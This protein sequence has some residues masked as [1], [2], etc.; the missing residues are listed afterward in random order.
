MERVIEGTCESKL[1][2]LYSLS[3]CLLQQEMETLVA[4]NVSVVANRWS[5]DG[6]RSSR[7]FTVR[8]IVEYRSANPFRAKSMTTFVR[9]RATMH[10]TGFKSRHFPD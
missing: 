7:N 2:G 1:R 4:A 5:S 3:C 8:E 9:V 10:P 6:G